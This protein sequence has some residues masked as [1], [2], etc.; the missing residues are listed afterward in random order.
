MAEP[1]LTLETALYSYLAA[2]LSAYDVF[3]T[4]ASGS[5]FDYIVFQFVGSADDDYHMKQRGRVYAYQIVGIQT[6]RSTALTMNAAIDAAMAGAKST[7]TVSGQALVRVTRTD[8]VDYTEITPD[9]TA[10]HHVG[11]VY[12]IELEDTP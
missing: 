1:K 12:E 7:V 11:G 8:V 9:G 2:Q 5:S 4:N 3:N 6:D 10:I